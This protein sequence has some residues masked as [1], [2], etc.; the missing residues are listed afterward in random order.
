[1]IGLGF[2]PHATAVALDDPLHDRQAHAGP[3]I[4]LGKMESLKHAK[5]LVDIAH[6]KTD[7]IVFD[8]IQGTAHRVFERATDLNPRM[9]AMRC[10][11]HGVRE[12]VHPDLLEQRR[13]RGTRGQIPHHD[14]D[15][16]A[17]PFLLQLFEAA[18][19][20][21][22]W[23]RVLRVERLTAEARKGEQIVHQLAHLLRIGPHVAQVLLC[24][25]RQHCGM[26]LQQDL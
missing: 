25:G 5:Q 6:V 23:L 3:L 11:L 15:A 13:V 14:F 17:S 12:Q 9:S 18:V 4:L 20:D 22:C 24:F 7:A 21:R 19:H 26:L 10:V 2:G 16:P 1:M 8:E